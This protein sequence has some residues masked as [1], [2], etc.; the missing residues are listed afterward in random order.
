MSKK[1]ALLMLVLLTL[2]LVLTACSTESRDAGKDYMEAVIHGEQEKA[3]ALA[4]SD[5]DGTADLLAWYASLNIVDDSADLQVDM[6]KGNNQKEL[7]VTGSFE[8]GRGV[9]FDCGKDNE[10][11]LSEKNDSL[12]TLKMKKED[13]DWCVSADSVFNG[14]PLGEM[15]EG[16]GEDADMDADSEDADS[17]DMDADTGSD[18]A[19]D[20]TSSDDADSDS[21]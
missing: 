18:D 13:G 17:E 16:E 9:E 7:H 20:D 1:F 14:T 4:C 10:F 5:F 8:C 2:S 12:I 19:G 21:E 3:E 6:A 11:V 15:G